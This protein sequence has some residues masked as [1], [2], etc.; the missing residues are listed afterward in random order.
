MA[1]NPKYDNDLVNLGYLNKRLE[2]TEKTVNENNKPVSQTLKN[3]SAP[4]NPPYYKDSLLCYGNKI[5]KCNNTKLQGVFSWSD[6]MI[7]ATDDTTINNF[8]NNVYE[9]DKIQIQE[10]IDN[11][12]QTYYQNEDP[13][14]EWATDLEKSKHIGDYWYNNTDNTQWRYNQITTSSP[15]TYKWEEVNIPN[16][17]FDMIDT[18]KSIYSK[19]P[20]SYKKDDLWIIEETISDEDLPEGTEEHPI[21]KGDWVF[22]NTDSDTYNKEHWEKRDEDITLSYLEEHYYT[23]EEIDSTFEEIE[24][25][26]DSKITKAKEEINL[27]VSQSYTTKEEHAKA[28]NDFDEQ[29]GTI[30]KSITEHTENISNLTIDIGGINSTVETI[31]KTT[32]T[33][34]TNI[35]DVNSDIESLTTEVNTTKQSIASL[36]ITTGNISAKV[37]SV[38]NEL[39]TTN[40]NVSDLSGNV[41]SLNAEV[42]ETTSLINSVQ[43]TLD[44]QK[45]R[46]DVISTNIDETNGNVTSVTTGKGFTFDDSGLNISDPNEGFNTL[47]TNKSTQYKNGEEIITE[48]STD[49][50]MTTDLKEKG[51]HQYNYDEFSDAYEMVA[52][53]V[54]IDGEYPYAHF[55]N[56]GDY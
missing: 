32:Q 6:W 48:T 13:A 34:E 19:K 38:E 16:A 26:T 52:E 18:K 30:N 21:A 45:A 29:I 55:Y 56:G 25:N 23:T 7:V 12:V 31:Q 50:F 33:L 27:N 14:R 8:V 39:S 37:S 49:G 36:E 35:E 44:T 46:I 20:T 41:E 4:P 1:Q 40:S 47:I 53:R 42:N 54:E 10:Q 24:R 43:L 15:I 5:Y 9:V 22:S 2:Q 51:S 17:V 11:K 3:Y 28:I